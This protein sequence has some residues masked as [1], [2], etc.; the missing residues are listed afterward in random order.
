[1]NVR[2]E[3]NI[4]NINRNNWS[5]FVKNH[6]NGNIFQ[7]PEI[8][9][10]YSRS[11]LYEPIT[12]FALNT[13][14]N[15]IGVLVVVI[16]REYKGLLGRFTSRAIIWGSPLVYS[17]DIAETLLS[18]YNKLVKR[19]AI[20][21]QF[22]NIFPVENIIMA[23]EKEGYRFQGHL[24]IIID[25]KKGK[26]IL[27]QEIHKNRKKEIR[28][29]LDRGLIVKIEKINVT[30]ILSVL[31]QMLQKLY[32]KIGLPIPSFSFFQNAVSILEPLNLL[33]TF[34]AYVDKRIVGFRMVLA[35]G[36]L[37]YDWYA[38]SD[39]DYLNYRINDI[40]PWEIMCWGCNEGY[41]TFDFGGAGNPNKPYGV[42]DYKIRFGGELVNY[43]RFQKIH[44]YALYLIGLA[45]IKT[46][47]LIKR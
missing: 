5:D 22:R 26:E 4:I 6:P 30:E 9:E 41:K 27:W 47:R 18:F 34:V 16:Q 25:L 12:L 38:A 7:T 24:N 36:P 20:Y 2:V 32:K 3:N 45:G 40:L 21:S 42:R 10:L 39:E 8:Y 37:I 1:M 17:A 33:F 19:K 31:F 14:N 35:Y 23:F 11:N 46:I 15:I 28:K 44:N 43:G 29:G 13:Q